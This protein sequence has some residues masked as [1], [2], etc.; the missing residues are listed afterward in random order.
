MIE[1][2]MRKLVNKLSH[3]LFITLLLF[4]FLD[5]CLEDKSDKNTYVFDTINL[6][7]SPKEGLDS[8]ETYLP[9]I[10]KMSKDE[11]MAFELRYNLSRGKNF[12]SLPEDTIIKSY[13]KYFESKQDTKRVLESYLLLSYACFDLNDYDL[14]DQSIQKGIATFEAE[15][16]PKQLAHLYST[17]GTIFHRSHFDSLAYTSFMLAHNLYQYA[18]DTIM[19]TDSYKDLGST[20]LESD[21]GLDSVL[22]Y[23][24]KALERAQLNKD[25]IRT[26]KML[27]SIAYVYLRQGHID[28]ANKVLSK[29][30]SYGSLKFLP[31]YLAFARYYKKKG[32]FEMMRNYCDSM[33]QLDIPRAMLQAHYKLFNAYEERE[34]YKRA[35]YHLHEY[36]FWSD[37]I[38]RDKRDTK[39]FQIESKYQNKLLRSKNQ[40][41]EAKQL[42]TMR[43]IWALIFITL[44]LGGLAYTWYTNHMRKKVLESKRNELRQ[45]NLHDR[46][47]QH[48]ENMKQENEVLKAQIKE[49]KSPAVELDQQTVKVH[50]LEARIK[51]A[52]MDRELRAPLEQQFFN[53]DVYKKVMK[54]A[55]GSTEETLSKDEWLQL[56]TAFEQTY[57]NL[58][59]TFK[60]IEYINQ[61]E[62]RLCCLAKLGVPNKGI[63]IL[64]GKA[65]S[66]VSTMKPRVYKKITGK[67]GSTNDFYQFINGL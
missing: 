25:S 52:E 28:E 58:L 22:I 59:F 39:L 65:E 9:L 7:F 6:D 49:N 44:I 46:S 37:S 36:T 24:N 54:L 27:S 43:G 18:N 64:L 16:F 21:V 3:S 41:L 62:I 1:L 29:T 63:S 47:L 42:A 60:Q 2:F 5:S 23:Y 66:T 50:L 67:K 13:I 4:L 57:D 20:M 26:N 48:I 33:I 38:K 12:L 51:K 30:A 15:K 8:L 14:V 32:D 34:D 35:Y 56:E 40:L 19:L 45:K 31:K 10:D 11:R 55:N 61:D 53:M 17:Q